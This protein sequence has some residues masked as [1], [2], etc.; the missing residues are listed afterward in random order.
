[1]GTNLPFYQH[2]RGGSSIDA[3][4]ARAELLFI[5]FCH[6][7]MSRINRANISAFLHSFMAF[8][9][10]NL[11]SASPFLNVTELLTFRMNGVLLSEIEIILLNVCK[12]ILLSSFI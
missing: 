3:K 4:A 1:M 2:V 8:R 12:Y 9:E 5:H 7:P 6:V 11:S 10:T